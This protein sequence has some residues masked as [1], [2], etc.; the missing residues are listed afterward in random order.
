VSDVQAKISR[1]IV[2]TRSYERTVDVELGMKPGQ[3]R[4]EALAVRVF[5]TLG[6]V[7]AWQDSRPVIRLE[8]KRT[9]KAGARTSKGRRYYDIEWLARNDG[10]PA[11][12]NSLDDFDDDTQD[13][14]RDLAKTLLVEFHDVNWTAQ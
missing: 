7:Y 1:R 11:K 12:W 14:L 8:V 13:R 4:A 2:E 9:T 5:Q 10:R 3:T 6:E